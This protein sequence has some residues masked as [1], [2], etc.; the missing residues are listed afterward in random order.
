MLVF[1]I[2][3]CAMGIKTIKAVSAD[4]IVVGGGDG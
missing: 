1:S 3:V 4:R 2:N